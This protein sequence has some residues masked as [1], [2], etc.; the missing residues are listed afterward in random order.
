MSACGATLIKG[1]QVATNGIVQV[2]DRVLYRFPG[3]SL[4][5]Y[6]QRNSKLRMLAMMM[7]I[8]GSQDKLNS[9]SKD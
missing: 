7:Q 5:N 1:D 3:E 8:A 4:S 9:K 6:I 2:I